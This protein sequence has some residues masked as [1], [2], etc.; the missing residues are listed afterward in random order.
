VR[1]VFT[2]VC[3]K[4]D[5]F[6]WRQIRTTIAVSTAGHVAGP[7]DKTSGVAAVGNHYVTRTKCYGVKETPI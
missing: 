1:D 6:T 3:D 7:A 5:Y 4:F 2:L